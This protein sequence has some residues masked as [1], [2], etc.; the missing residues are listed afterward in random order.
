M[1]TDLARR[2]TAEAPLYSDLNALVPPLLDEERE[3]LIQLPVAFKSVPEEVANALRTGPPDWSAPGADIALIPSI[4]HLLSLLALANHVEGHDDRTLDLLCMVLELHRLSTPGINRPADH[5]IATRL[6]GVASYQSR[7]ISIGLKLRDSQAPPDGG[8]TREQV[9]RLIGLL[10]DESAPFDGYRAALCA[11]AISVAR[12]PL[13]NSSDAPLD[14]LARSEHAKFLSTFCAVI[15]N[16]ETVSWPAVSALTGGT[17][18]PPRTM[19]SGGKGAVRR[20][21]RADLWQSAFRHHRALTGRRAAAIAL[22]IR[23][24]RHDHDDH[25][26]ARLEDLV[27]DYL[28]H[29]PTDPFAPPG[30]PFRYLPEAEEPCFYSVGYNGEDDG[31]DIS[32]GNLSGLD[33]RRA[34]WDRKDVVFRLRPKPARPNSATQ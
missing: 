8:A 22:A 29:V 34:P 31:A 28:P 16:A 19:L 17:I 14:L 23:L 20:G 21:F 24:Y 30:V 33:E 3:R 4:T 26:P 5:E 12:A 11:Q 9:N 18:D 6:S 7:G 2:V 32:G 15:E 10:M 1:L 27:P 25:L 13:P